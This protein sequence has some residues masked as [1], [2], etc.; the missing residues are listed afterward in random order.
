LF[1]VLFVHV[2]NIVST[3]KEAGQPLRNLIDYALQIFR[4]K[5]HSVAENA[6]LRMISRFNQFQHLAGH[7]DFITPRSK[8]PEIGA[9]HQRCAEVG[10]NQFFNGMNSIAG[11][12]RE[13]FL[14]D[15]EDVPA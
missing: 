8:S 14:R 1:K 15:R 12:C 2:A 11:D 13:N 7:Q 5:T 6:A 9:C 10:A 4:I 3:D